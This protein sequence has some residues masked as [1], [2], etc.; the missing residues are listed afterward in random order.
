P[1]SGA[2]VKDLPDVALEDGDR[3]Y[4]PSPSSTVNVM[5]MVYNQTAFLFRQDKSVGDYLA[6]AGGPTRDGDEGDVY[7]VREDGTVYSK[8]QG[9]LIFSGFSSRD[10]MPGDTIIVPEKLDKF[11]LTKVLRDWTQ[12]FYQFA[13]AAAGGK[14]AKMW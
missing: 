14:A 2:Q 11:N 5:G 9:G 13:L 8:R 3:F 7:L 1:D 10:A 12:I 4:V 6:K